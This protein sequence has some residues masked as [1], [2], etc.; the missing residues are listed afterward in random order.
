[1]QALTNSAFLQALGYAIANS[2][3][4]M[5]LLWI[6]FVLVTGIFKLNANNKYKVAA[7]SQLLGFVWFAVTFQFYYLQCSAAIKESTHF[8]SQNNFALIIPQAGEGFRSNMINFMLKAEQL[9]PYLSVA[10]LLLLLFLCA[11]WIRSYQHAQT[12]RTSGLHKIDV[13]WKLFVKRV[14]EQLGI[15]KK[16]RIYLSEHITTPMTIGFLKPIILVPLASINHLSAEQMEA[17]LLHELAHIKRFDYLLNL[18]LSV[19]EI[20]LFFNPFTQLISKA[21]KK[22]RENSCDDWV[23]QFQYNPSMYAEAL[24]RIAYLQTAP[25]FAMTA[26]NKS[27]NDL[28][29]RVKRMIDNK[30]AR[31]NYKQQLLALFLMTGILSSIAWF[32]PMG[33]T[34]SNDYNVKLKTKQT[35]ILEPMAAKVSNPFFNPVFFLQQPLKDEIEKA[36][37]QVRNSSIQPKDLQLVQR[38]LATVIP[39]AAKNLEEINWKDVNKNIAESMKAVELQTVDIARMRADSSA[40]AKSNSFFTYDFTYDGYDDVS[41][42][43]QKANEDL[44]KAKADFRTAYNAK[45][46]DWVKI[47]EAKKVQQELTNLINQ[48]K[49]QGVPFI[50]NIKI[51]KFVLTKDYDNEEAAVTVNAGHRT[52]ETNRE[53][54]TTTKMV[55]GG[56]AMTKNFVKLD[57]IRGGMLQLR[58][59]KEQPVHFKNMQGTT[60]NGVA[61]SSTATASAVAQQSAATPPQMVGIGGY[62]PE[63]VPNAFSYSYCSDSD[64]AT[65]TVSNDNRRETRIKVVTT[66][67]TSKTTSTT[68]RS[69]HYEIVITNKDNSNKK[70]IIEVD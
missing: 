10:Y 36:A 27:K 29:S 17:V 64:A 21:I 6:V 38:E 11:K 30:D 28:L 39:I 25:A 54:R 55:M 1:M 15:K 44:K 53:Q 35:L 31:F 12:I 7:S 60:V 67:K 45:E 59:N 14:A 9:L 42:T 69:K 51:P 3:W 48:L 63:V 41:K 24:L 66:S 43:F 47:T 33:S 18:I 32:Q 56:A 2:L 52:A 37:K 13:D 5:A 4:Q 22:E 65:T 34:P 58:R 61:I 49:K 8:A 57:S 26:V 70:V 16:V 68:S 19:V 62:I 50:S 46:R 20:V 23:L 40:Y